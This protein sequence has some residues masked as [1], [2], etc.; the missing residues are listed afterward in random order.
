MSRAVV[1]GSGP[2]GLAAAIRL[3][4]AGL[5][6]T[7]L[8]AYSRPGGGTRTDDQLT[9]PGVV[10]DVCAAFHPTGV[11][12]PYLAS[13]DLGRHG[14]RWLWPEVDLAHPLDDGRAALAA[15]DMELSVASLGV[16]GAR[17]RRI[18]DPV[19]RNFDD[20]IEEVFQ[21]VLHVPR[22]PVTL[23]RFGVKALTPAT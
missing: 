15:R 18:F 11:A 22:H 14:L 1:V 6:V 3:A 20:L 17:W 8:E 13:L 5:E 19:V 23:G 7:V 4:Q 2:N 12:S 10:H 21:P 16:D 9:V